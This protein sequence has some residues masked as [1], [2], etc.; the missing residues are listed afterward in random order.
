M[1]HRVRERVFH[2][3]GRLRKSCPLA[4]AQERDRIKLPRRYRAH[5]ANLKKEYL[6]NGNSPGLPFIIMATFNRRSSISRP[7]VEQLRAV[8]AIAMGQKVGAG[9]PMSTYEALC[10]LLDDGLARG[11]RHWRRR[12]FREILR[13]LEREFQELYCRQL[14]SDGTWGFATVFGAAQRTRKSFRAL[15]WA[16]V[17]HSLHLPG[18]VDS[19]ERAF[20]AL[21]E[22]H[23]EVTGP[24]A[25]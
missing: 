6:D 7:P 20:A 9:R 22:I 10:W 11:G 5:W 15:R 1:S 17:R 12:V 24:A 25:A 13:G 21:R 18:A 3:G 19:A 23:R 14:T 4:N 2:N 8:L 16:A